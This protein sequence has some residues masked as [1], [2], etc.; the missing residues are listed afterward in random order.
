MSTCVVTGGAG[1]L[2][3]HLCEHLLAK[4]H[5]VIC[6]DNLETGSLQNIA[7]IREDAFEFRNMGIGS[8]LAL[9]IVPQIMKQNATNQAFVQ[10]EM[11]QSAKESATA[12]TQ[13]ADAM[14]DLGTTIKGSVDKLIDSQDDLGTE[15][16]N[17][18]SELLKDLAPLVRQV[19][20]LADA[21]EERVEA[22]KPQQPQDKPPTP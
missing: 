11:I 7:H 1:F 22:E 20:R 13:A 16:R 4:G 17:Q 21:V 15:L 14:D 9:L 6:I 10:T 3:S 5:R 8:V 18:Q 19:D 2:G 12:M